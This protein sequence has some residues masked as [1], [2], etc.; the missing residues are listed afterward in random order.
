MPS[1]SSKNTG[2]TCPVTGMFA[3]FLARNGGEE[4]ARRGTLTLSAAGSRARTSATP[5][6]KPESPEAVPDCGPNTPGSFAWFDRDSSSWKTWQRCFI[7]GLAAF[8][9]T[10]PRAGMTRNGTAFRLVPLVPLTAVTGCSS[11][12]TPTAN[13]AKNS[14]LPES[15][16]FRDSVVGY[17]LNY[18]TPKA[19]DF[20]RGGRGELLAL[21]RGKKTRQMWPTPDATDRGALKCFTGTRPSGTK[22]S[23]TLQAAVGGRLNPIFVEWLMGFPLGWSDLEA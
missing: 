9:E 22:E 5:G 12:P 14:T 1:A 18:P 4:S 21:V 7:E 3:T 17:V 6:S 19:S 10:W 11:L 13:D 15:Q 23:L 16:R 20:E 2:P 8:S